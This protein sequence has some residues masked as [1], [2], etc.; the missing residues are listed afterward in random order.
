MAK[1]CKT[2][3]AILDCFQWWC[4]NSKPSLGRNW[5]ESGIGPTD[6]PKGPCSFWGEYMYIGSK[7]MAEGK[8]QVQIITVIFFPLAVYYVSLQFVFLFVILNGCLEHERLKT[9]AWNT[10]YW[11]RMA[12][13]MKD[14]DPISFIIVQNIFHPIILWKFVGH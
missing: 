6:S 5:G 8:S 14:C 12:W 1:G 3:R 10:K 7:G 9:V 13:N 4:L 11:K 2:P